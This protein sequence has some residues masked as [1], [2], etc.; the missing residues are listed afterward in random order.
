MRLIIALSISVFLF[1]CK[2]GTVPIEY[3]HDECHYC[4]MTI[5]NK[6]YGAELV[7]DKG[8]VL[9]FDAIECLVHYIHDTPELKTSFIV[10]NT[11]DMPGELLNAQSCTYLISK[12]LPSPM[13]AN[14]TAF[15]TKE[16][17]IDMQ[18]SKPG[19]IFTW[20]ELLRKKKL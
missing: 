8:K 16:K 4:S 14:L 7:T 1:G 5:V 3:G 19:N 17:A 18:E 2:P 9:K 6:Q 12:E 15:S 10:V 13:G 20:D 11:F